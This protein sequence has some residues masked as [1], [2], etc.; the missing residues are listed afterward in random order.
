MPIFVMFLLW[1]LIEIALFVK[2]G[3]TLGIWLTLLVVLGTGLLGI[4]ILR[5]ETLKS[6]GQLR[7]K[8]ISLSKPL[9]AAGSNALRVLAGVLLVLPGFLTDILGLLLFIPIV[10]LILIKLIVRRFG[11]GSVKSKQ[12]VHHTNGIIIEGEFTEVKSDKK[13]PS[14]GWTQH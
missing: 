3:S 8:I 6:T 9:T 7:V 5:E 10:Q 13:K 14:S 1:P 12:S 4:A 2:I 11:I